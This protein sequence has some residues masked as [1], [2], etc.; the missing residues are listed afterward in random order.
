LTDSNETLTVP[1]DIAK[2]LK[3]RAEDAG[4]KSLQD[5]VTY[6]L[7][8]VLSKVEAEEI[9]KETLPKQEDEE[10]IKQKLR[11]LGYLD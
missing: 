11:D 10:E 7:R 5:Y 6:I 9:Q 8:Q 1:E 4:F 2:K 3:K